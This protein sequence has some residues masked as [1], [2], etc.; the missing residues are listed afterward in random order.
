MGII[1]I[2]TD[3]DALKKF[4]HAIKYVAFGPTI[5]AIPPKQYAERFIKFIESIIE[6]C[7]FFC[8]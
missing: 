2:L 5:S 6:T 4:E 8:I 7:W 1:D 3:F